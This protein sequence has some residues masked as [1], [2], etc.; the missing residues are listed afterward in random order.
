M[1]PNQEAHDQPY[2]FIG[3]RGFQTLLVLITLISVP[4]MLL[5]KPLV[6][7]RQVTLV[8]FLSLSDSKMASSY[9]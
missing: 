1:N 7:L 2:L 5:A 3:E 8:T 6:I 9:L 4:W